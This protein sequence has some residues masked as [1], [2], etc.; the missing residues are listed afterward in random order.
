MN[1]ELGYEVR[2]QEVT[3]LVLEEPMGYSPQLEWEIKI[4]RMDSGHLLSI[5]QPAEGYNCLEP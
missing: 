4:I 3:P 2:V 1:R 5:L